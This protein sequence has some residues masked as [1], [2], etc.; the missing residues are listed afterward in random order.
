MI[1][2][3]CLRTCTMLLPE[4]IDDMME[5][6][7]ARLLNHSVSP[8]AG[9]CSRN[10]TTGVTSLPGRA[11]S[12]LALVQGAFAI[13]QANPRNLMHN[14]MRDAWCVAHQLLDGDFLPAP[15]ALVCLKRTIQ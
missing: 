5:I 3:P 6:S 10:K 2:Q 11:A 4:L 8:D 13:Q 14:L 15:Q 1:G 9:R 7:R 12:Q